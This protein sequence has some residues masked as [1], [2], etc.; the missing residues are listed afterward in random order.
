[1]Q[2]LSLRS[3]PFLHRA[4]A[5]SFPDG[6]PITARRFLALVDKGGDDEMFGW[7]LSLAERIDLTGHM[8]SL[9]VLI[10]MSESDECVPDHV[11]K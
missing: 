4:L 9:P 10:M 2:L 3:Y 7:E 11:D 1:M 6:V 5:H 8:A